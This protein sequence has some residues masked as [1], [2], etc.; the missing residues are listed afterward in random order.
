MPL[1]QACGK[2]NADDARFC[3]SCG[4]ALSRVPP[5]KVEVKSPITGQTVTPVPPQQPQPIYT[6]RQIQGIGSCYYH[7]DLPSAYVCARCGRSICAGCNRQYGA[8]S[9]CT[10]CYYVLSPKINAAQPTY[11]YPTYPSYYPQPEQSRHSFF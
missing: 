10:E 3:F 6:P 5:V 7:H 8:L 2:P 4:A 9:F 11:Q 1:C